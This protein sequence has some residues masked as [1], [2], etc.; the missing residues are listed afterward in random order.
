MSQRL[1][2]PRVDS[3]DLRLARVM[4]A[5]SLFS[6]V[7]FAIWVAVL[8]YAYSRGGAGLAGLVGVA[9][10]LPAAVLAPIFGSLGDRLPRGAA[11]SGAYAAEAL[12]LAAVAILLLE[13]API[14]FV[15]VAA[16]SVTTANSVARPIHYAALPQLASTPRALVSANAASGVAEGIG[17]FVGPVV[18]GLL[19]QGSGPWLV[20]ALSALAM[21]GASILATRLRLP[22]A[23]ARADGAGALRSAVAGL[24]SV[25]S[26]RS[27][28]ALLF[29]V[30]VVFLVGGSL[31]VL[32]VSF[33]QAVLHGGDSAAGLV[34]GATG[35]GALIGAAAAAGLAFRVRLAAPTT[36][37]LVAAG[38][39][40]LVM[41]AVSGLPPAVVLLA[42]SGLGQAFTSVAGRT[43]LQR[44]TDDRVLARVFAV[45]EGVMMAGVAGGAALAPLLIRR[46]GAARG[47]LPLGLGLVVIAVLA[48]P[49]LKRLDLRALVR[50]DV[51]AV[52]R[53]V[54]FLAAVSPP[55]IERLSKAAQW[56]EVKAGDIVIR[57][58]DAGEAFY[59]IA[60]G[61]LSV[62]VDGDVRDHVLGEGDGFGEIA[63][64]RDVPRTA[65]VTA[66]QPC[67]LLRIERPDFLAAITGTADGRL[68]A[69]QVAVAHLE[70]D[71]HRR[72]L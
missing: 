67:R 30:G 8:L 33:A 27:V 70:R 11:L 68:I 50:S 42:L 21:L 47:Y 57:Q 62:E 69:A 1:K 23:S 20:A 55:A 48:W 56:V 9:Q 45:Q 12:T 60:E 39:P 72:D 2:T 40:L 28:L 38:L 17:V 15:V 66:I 32:G 6:V 7:N 46:F 13:D 26:D 35:I 71:A 49:M 25:S 18:A 4:I 44:S 34:V 61:L 64:L 59:V 63:L 29:V 41:T 37:G 5:F 14:G 51:L 16:A 52:L 10:L 58:G 31:E 53:R 65:T 22:V 54:S 19:A 43:L 24:R 3:R 36:L